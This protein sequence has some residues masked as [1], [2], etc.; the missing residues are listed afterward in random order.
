MKKMIKI[1][2]CC[3][4]SDH[5]SDWD[6]LLHSAE[7]AYN[8]ATIS[9]LRKCAFELDMGWIPRLPLNIVS[10]TSEPLAQNVEKLKKRLQLF[11]DDARSSL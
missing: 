5:Q 10:I 8:S 3:Y 6:E 2:L 1:Y 11:L 9:T 4:C 7:I